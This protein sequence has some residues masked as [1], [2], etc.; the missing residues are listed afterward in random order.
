MLRGKRKICSF[1]QLARSQA[2]VNRIAKVQLAA[3]CWA[4]RI[5]FL[6][7]VQDAAPD[8]L[9]EIIVP[10]PAEPRRDPRQK[11]PV[12]ALRVRL[13]LRQA[14][15]GDLNIQILRPGQPQDRRQIDLELIGGRGS[16]GT[17]FRSPTRQASTEP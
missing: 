3:D 13:R 2:F 4:H 1:D 7:Y 12:G 15:A 9:Q 11:L 6:V 10:F 5:G 16:S 14:L 17:A 8:V